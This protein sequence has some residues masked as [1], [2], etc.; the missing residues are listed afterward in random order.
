M[1]QLSVDSYM[2]LCKQNNSVS[3]NKAGVKKLFVCRHPTLRWREGSVGRDFFILMKVSLV[4]RAFSIFNIGL[5]A[6]KRNYN[7]DYRYNRQW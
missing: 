4:P 1:E 7:R 3:I 6:G 2:W 5:V